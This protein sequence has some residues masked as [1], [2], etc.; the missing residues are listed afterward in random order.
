MS[1]TKG[2]LYVLHKDL[3]L[4]IDGLGSIQLDIAF[5]GIFIK[6]IGSLNLKTQKEVS[7]VF[8]QAGIV[9]VVGLISLQ[10]SM[11]WI[12]VSSV[13]SIGYLSNGEEVIALSAKT[14][15]GQTGIYLIGTEYLHKLGA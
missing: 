1:F 12:G 5:G 11:A 4:G 3:N 10:I 7:K 14:L 6:S 15:F 2:T 9:T 13:G 8:F